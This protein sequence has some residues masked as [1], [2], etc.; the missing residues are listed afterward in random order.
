MKKLSVIGRFSAVRDERFGMLSRAALVFVPVHAGKLV[1]AVHGDAK[2]V[3][4][5]REILASARMS[6]FES[7]AH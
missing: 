1:L 6:T 5:A 7:A 4:R 3:E 2:E